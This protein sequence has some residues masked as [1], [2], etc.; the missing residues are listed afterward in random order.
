MSLAN[1]AVEAFAAW[2]QA[3]RLVGVG[4]AVACSTAHA[5]KNGAACAVGATSAVRKVVAANRRIRAELGLATGMA[6]YMHRGTPNQLMAAKI[7]RVPVAGASP[8]EKNLAPR[9][10]EEGVEVVAQTDDYAGD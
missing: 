6:D 7:S 5:S 10:L 1:R 9:L 3:G 2:T 4:V 8:V